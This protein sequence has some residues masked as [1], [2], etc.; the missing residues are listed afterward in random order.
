MSEADWVRVWTVSVWDGFSQRV[1]DAKGTYEAVTAP[2][3]ALPP[4]YIWSAH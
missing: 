2:L 1:Y 3:R 4:S